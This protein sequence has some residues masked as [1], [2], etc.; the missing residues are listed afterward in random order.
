MHSLRTDVAVL[1]AGLQGTSIVLELA[2][3]GIEVTLVERDALALNRAS[4]RNEGKIHLGLIY[5]NEPSRA[6]A[7]LQLHGALAFRSLLA[8]W[9]DVD[10]GIVPSTPF[11]YLVARDSVLGLDALERHYAEIDERAS[12]E[13]AHDPTLDYLGDRHPSATRR[14]AVA[15]IGAHFDRERFLG[16]F[17]TAERA[18]DCERMAAELRRA[19][20]AAPGLTFLPA[21]TARAIVGEGDGFRVE[22]DGREGTW[23]LHARQV[24]NATWESRAALDATMGFPPPPGLLHRLKYR[25]IARLPL[26]LRQAPSVT[27][28]LGRYGD[29]VVRSDGT[30]YLSWYPDVLR[31]WCDRLAP[32]AQWDAACRGE[33]Q[34]DERRVIVQDVL[35]SIDAWFPGIRRCRPREVDAGVVVAIGRSD[36]D[37]PASGLHARCR[38]GVTSR[39]GYHSVDPGKLTTAPLFAVE[40]AD[41]IHARRDARVRV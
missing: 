5:A 1:G 32:P 27:M 16:G 4:L 7:F 19:L 8:R 14:L 13:L 18:I 12:A 31:G 33:V 3:R 15:E 22:G 39:D 11:Y 38:V 21:R 36:V 6:T 26:D 20:L 34:A 40:A 28:V 9:I 37:D 2:R 30:A 23:A 17:A 41:R 25:L 29:V 24:V 10:R 35:A